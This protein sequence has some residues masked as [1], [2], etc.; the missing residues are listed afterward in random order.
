MPDSPQFSPF[1]PAPPEPPSLQRT[2]VHIWRASLDPP[3]TR[4]ESLHQL[5][6]ADELTRAAR[7]HFEK[8]RR[9][10]TSARGY[11][12]ELLSRYL[13]SDPREIRFSYTKYGKPSLA[14][15]M[16]QQL[17]FNVAHSG[18]AA[19]YAVTRI[20]EIGV[21]LEFI[22]PEFTGDE[23]AR[24]FFSPAEVASLDQVPE[25]LR[26][27]AFFACWTR[28][29]AFIKAKGLGLSLG[30][31]QFDVTLQADHPVAVLRTAWDESEA[32]RWSLAAID[33]GPDFAAA[34]ALEAKDW[35][36][37]YWQVE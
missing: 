28:K 20:G 36:A 31:N 6:S 24:R 11:L 21:D 32:K 23:I 12:R 15:G 3:A 16:D 30:L 18:G 5:L 25:T 10:F 7:Y 9:H 13:G 2:D 29:E 17:K 33:A 35:Q 8:D 14:A 22:R 1:R 37:S 4:L 19:L 26:H 34:V 27:R